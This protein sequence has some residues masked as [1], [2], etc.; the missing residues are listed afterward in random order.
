M[1]RCLTEFYRGC[2][3]RTLREEKFSCEKE[4]LYNK[5]SIQSKL[6]YWTMER[7]NTKVFGIR[8]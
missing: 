7:E 8:N 6:D 5:K 4:A 1:G 2:Q 3:Q